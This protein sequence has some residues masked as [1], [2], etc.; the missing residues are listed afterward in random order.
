MSGAQAAALAPLRVIGDN[1]PNVN[2]LWVDT[3]NRE[4][5]VANDGQETLPVNS[6]QGHGVVAAVREVKGRNTF[7]SFPGQVFVG[8]VHGKVWWVGNDTADLVTVHPRTA[9]GDVAPVRTLNLRTLRLNRT[10]GLGR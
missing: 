2:T 3:V 5:V 7:V 1:D 4:I 9:N 10:W 8:P 6:A